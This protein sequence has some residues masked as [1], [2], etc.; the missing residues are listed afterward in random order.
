MI[1]VGM[2]VVISRVA[3]YVIWKK[4]EELVLMPG[5]L[6]GFTNTCLKLLINY[7]TQKH[8]VGALGL[9]LI[10][11]LFGMNQI[12]S[13]NRLLDLRGAPVVNPIY[14]PTLIIA[15]VL[16]NSFTFHE[17]VTVE[18]VFGIIIIVFAINDNTLPL[19]PKYIRI[20]SV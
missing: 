12:H 18:F 7:I 15:I 14:I 11:C 3:L 17:D 2:L 13:L 4:K 19:N 6:G 8:I 10:T 16:V 9:L 5:I 20:E 1:L